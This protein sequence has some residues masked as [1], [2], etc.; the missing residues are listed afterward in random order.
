MIRVVALIAAM[1]VVVLSCAAPA[2]AQPE[3][4]RYPSRP[5]KLIVPFPAGTLTDVVARTFADKL[6]MQLDKPVIVEDRPGAG[7]TVGGK[8]VASSDPDGYTLLFTNSQYAIAPSVY[9]TLGYD[10]LVD[11]VGVALVAE[12]PSAVI[13]SPKMGVKTLKD[14]IAAAKSQPEAF[15]YASAGT[16]SQTHLAAEYFSRQAGIKLVHLPYRDT[17]AIISD[18]ISGRTQATFAPPGFLLGQIQSGD[19]LALAVTSRKGMTAPIAAPSV[20]ETAIPGYEYS[21]WFGFFAPAHTPSAIVERLAS[22]LGVATEDAD[23]KTK[24]LKSAVI[25]GFVQ[26]RDFDA[27]VKADISKQAQIVKAAGIVPQ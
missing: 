26:L 5:I 2:C 21:T 12:S 6:S 20:S 17:G 10:T 25:T 11:F 14:F 1:L 18:M 24:L 22:A 4:D 19:L 8:A 27:F 9:R 23:L 16:G 13:V 3:A 15:V 7:G